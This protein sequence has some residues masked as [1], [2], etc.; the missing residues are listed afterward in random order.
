MAGNPPVQQM[1]SLLFEKTIDGKSVGIA[2]LCIAIT[3]AQ[4]LGLTSNEEIKSVLIDRVSQHYY[5]P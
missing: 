2:W 5:I 1:H 3:K 4:A